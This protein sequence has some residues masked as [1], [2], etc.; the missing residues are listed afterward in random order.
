MSR[1][2]SVNISLPKEINHKGK[3]ISSGIFK[4]PVKGR[5][6]V[7]TLNLEGDGQADLLAHG[8]KFRAVYV[9]SYDNYAYWEKELKRDDFKYGQFGENFTVE[10]MLDEEIHVGD[11]FKIGTTLFEVTQP[12]VPCYKLAIK[13]G[14]E[15]FYNQILSSGRLGF[16]FRVV[17]EGEVGA[18]DIIEKVSEDP[19]KMTINDVNRLLYYSKDDFDGIEK[20]IKIKAL[21]PGWKTSFEDRLAKADLSEQIQDKYITLTVSKKV[22]ESQTITSFYLVSEDGETLP[23][24]LPGQ[25]LPLKLD[26]PGQ[27][28]PVIRTYSIS[29]SP[30]KEYYRLTIKR[31]LAP[32]D[33]PDLYPGVS[34]NYFHD[35]V[36]PGTKLLAKA[37]RGK[38]FLDSKDENPIVLLSAGVGLTPLISMMNAIIDSESNQEVWFV[39]GTRNSV[40]HAMGN[41]IRKIAEQN[42]N[43]HVHVAYSKPLKGDLEGRDYDSKGYVDIELLKKILPGN[44]AEF[45]LCG[46]TPFMK[47]LFNGLLEWKVPEYS[48]NYEFFGPASQLKDRARVSTPK[49]SAGAIDCSGEIE[50]EFSRSGVKTNWNPSF[51]S[52]LDLAEASGLTPDY[53]CRSGICHTCMCKL[54]DGEVDYIEEPLD[55]PEEGCVLICVSKPKK[56]IIVDI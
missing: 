4:E 42:D 48:I 53:S 13:M 56:N 39:H 14:V 44:K 15:G 26:I 54:K 35:E 6:K 32:S 27:Y 43:I 3:K 24:F 20:A 9:Y 47:S 10:G 19:Q 25:F 33:R 37:P 46:P 49:R 38:F 30:N 28:K 11:R 52:I 5:V 17:K 41:H 55:P 21:S 29:D 45:Y 31:E 40:E 7:N 1:L 23:P 12:R 8:G 2:L 16:Y 18:G 22:P 50:V 51:E 36:E 34:S